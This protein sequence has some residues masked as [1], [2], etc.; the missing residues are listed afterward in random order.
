MQ[1]HDIPQ[2]ANHLLHLILIIFILLLIRIWYLSIIQHDH[3]LKQAERPQ[4]KTLIT[5]SSRGTIRD[6][7]GIP[8]AIN[9]IQYHAAVCFDPI[10]QIPRI[11]FKK[12]PQG[13]KKR[14]YKRASYIEALSK[15]LGKQL[16]L[17]PID[18]EDTI[19]AKAAIF[20]NTP[21]VIKKDISEKVYY[22]LKMLEKDWI[23]LQALKSSQRV[24]PQGKTGGNLVG[25]MGAIN[26][27]EY[28][29]FAEKI[30]LL[31]GFLKKRGEGEIVPL[32]KGFHSVYEVQNRLAELEE[33]MYTI[34]DQVGKTGIEAVFDQELRGYY[35]KKQILTDA[36]GRLIQEFPI[37]REAIPGN[38][39]ILTLSSEL[40]AYA[41][42]LLIEN[43]SIR[44]DH[45]PFAGKN[46]KQIHPPWILGG[47]IVAM[48][49]QTGEILALASYPRFDPNDFAFK[50]TNPISKWL[51]A[52]SYI[53]GIWDGKTPLSKEV[54]SSHSKKCY[55]K[56]LFLNWDFYLDSILSRQSQVRQTLKNISSIQEA[57]SILEKVKNLKSLSQ[58]DSIK[59]LIE[60][61]YS[62]KGQGISK[63]PNLISI[64]ESL[65][66]YLDPIKHSSDKLLFLDLLRLAL[67]DT[68]F[69]PSLLELIGFDSLAFY[70]S[71]NQA[72][73]IIEDHV[74]QSIRKLYSL[75]IFP[76]WR[77]ENFKAFLNEKRKKETLKKT[78]Q[79]P[80]T[81]YLKEA[82]SYLFEAFWEKH[83]WAF[84]STFLFGSMNKDPSLHAF[85]YHLMLKYQN[86]KQ[87]NS[88]VYQHLQK[89]Q[90]RLN[91]LPLPHALAY[92]KTLRS[93]SELKIPLWGHYFQLRRPYKNQTFQD[94]A[95]FFYPKYGY[96]FCKSYGFQQSTT[97][98][99]LFKIVTGYEAL[100]ESYFKQKETIPSYKRLNPLTIYD[101]IH[102]HIITRQGI[103]LGYHLDGKQITR[104]Y[105]GGRLPKSHANLGKID[106]VR[107]IARSSN[108]YF[109]LLA[110][111][112]I[113]SPSS[114][115]KTTLK[116]GFGKKTNI[117]LIGEISGFVPDDIRD[118]QTAL[119]SF[120]IGQH[121]LVVTPLQVAIMFSA[122]ANGGHVLKPKLC[123]FCEGVSLFKDPSH[124][125]NSP[126]FSYREHLNSIGID[127]PFFIETQ[128]IWEK[129]KSHSF[130]TTIRD[131]IPL[132]KE[133][134]AK[135]FE[136]M[137]HV[138]WGEEGAANPKKICLLAQKPKM[139]R[140]YRQLKN[141][142]IGKTATAEFVYRPMLDREMPPLLCKDIWFGALSFKEDPKNL[143]DPMKAE[144]EL[145]IVIYLRF[146]DYGKEAAPL[147]AQMIKK[148]REIKGRS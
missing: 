94:L 111:D 138:V 119:Y 126:F 95:T 48:V 136:G 131:Q 42:S 16:Q 75:H 4:K 73:A 105:K 146:G 82:K 144:A 122:I 21:F 37:K 120:A 71:Q 101:E 104:H 35:G 45:F 145:A 60:I 24:Y 97:L 33:K 32:P 72:F 70:R 68:V 139:M 78:Y 74:K 83:R 109:S 77:Q 96:G 92:L 52:P 36:K 143:F 23:G 38:R 110:G 99:S 1:N 59:D 30:T 20:P 10:R 117:D 79:H 39:L 43:E 5:S 125:F 113:K 18:I 98:G 61:F 51:E 121:S 123:A 49:P 129:S 26:S 127:F 108:L 132:P 6:R 90:K 114:L 34:H 135:L 47:A 56:E 57:S 63:P 3:Y 140:E 102:S 107:A 115:Y 15:F 66:P 67:N 106:F 124:L 29:S 13:K 84:L 7:F 12:D 31:K 130:K 14:L 91:K 58:I 17:N 76:L 25:Y 87:T 116:I 112:V 65:D 8:L 89:L 50:K 22:R 88:F 2:K 142:F 44:R 9:K 103:V 85:S 27:N 69:P 134:Q 147:V 93:F 148:W 137:Y 81:D 128:K 54:L 100:K 40:Q 141:Q 80:Y 118:N 53:A 41:E 62:K 133:I 11:C 28:F 55:E 19:Y 64:K 46:H 86:I